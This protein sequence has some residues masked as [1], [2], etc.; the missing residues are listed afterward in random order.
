MERNGSTFIL[1]PAEQR[2]FGVPIVKIRN[3]HSFYLTAVEL[4]HAKQGQGEEAAR[5]PFTAHQGDARSYLADAAVAGSVAAQCAAALGIDHSMQ[6]TVEAFARE[7][8]DYHD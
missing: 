2:V 5:S 8:A 4:A 7:I 1:T 3:L 6:A